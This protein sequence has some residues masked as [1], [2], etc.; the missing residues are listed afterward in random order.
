MTTF[1]EALENVASGFP[2][3]SENP[4][5]FFFLKAANTLQ[6]TIIQSSM[7]VLKGFTQHK[8]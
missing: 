2:K 8:L 5:R 1:R 6:R 4:S 3:G 7:K